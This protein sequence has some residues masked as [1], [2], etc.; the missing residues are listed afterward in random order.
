MRKIE[1]F[2]TGGGV[3]LAEAVLDGDLIAVV[4]NDAPEHLDIYKKPE[5]DEENYLPEDMVAS[6]HFTELAEDLKNLHT[7][8]VESLKARGYLE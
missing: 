4:G 7:Q 6:T 3:A 8:M 1:V 5:E 2:Y